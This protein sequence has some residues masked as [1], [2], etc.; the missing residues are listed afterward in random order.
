MRLLHVG[1][2]HIGKLV[3]GFSMLEDQ[4]HI[5]GQV[6]DVADRHQ[7]D[8]VLIAGDLYDRSQPSAETVS[9]VSDFLGQMADRH[10]ACFCVAGNHDSP[11]RVAYA[12]SLMRREGVYVSPVFDGSLAHFDLSDEWGRVTF[13]LMPYL[14]PVDVRDHYPDAPIGQDY[15]EAIRAVVEACPIDAETRNVLVAHQFVTVQGQ[16]TQRSDSELSIG[17]LDAVD[18][19][20]FDPFDYVAL[21]HIHRPQRVGR[22]TLRYA[23]SPL[24][25]SASEI[26]YPKSV[27]LV[28]LRA[29]GEASV[30]LVPLAPLHDMR[31]IQGP[32][33]ELVSAEV[34][35]DQEA[36]D[37]LFVTLTDEVQ[38]PDALSRLRQ[39][40]PNVMGIDFQNAGTTAVGAAGLSL[41]EMRKM[42]PLDLFARLFEE[43]N[44]RQLMDE[45]RDLVVSALAQTLGLAREG[46]DG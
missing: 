22:D 19:S 26:P 32:L 44:G 6:L 11:E 15:T 42:D 34:V 29:K 1:D 4:R 13:W 39:A 8:A 30:D 3:N 24:K 2:L 17:G 9:L 18:A 41:D 25:Y 23:G 38:Q 45:E 35:Q 27:C 28:D 40:Y 10:L 7:V 20:V 31:R 5:L 46:S 16:T 12:S 36:D 37:Y 21:G 43:Q 33:E 14:R